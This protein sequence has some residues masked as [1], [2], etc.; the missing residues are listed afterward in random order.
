MSS[1]QSKNLA[2]ATA[3]AM[4]ATIG[5][6]IVSRRQSKEGESQKSVAGTASVNEM[7]ERHSGMNDMDV[8]KAVQGKAPSA[9]YSSLP[10]VGSNLKFVSNTS[11]QYLSTISAHPMY[12]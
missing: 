9:A 3:F 6:F 10:A 4:A 11:K 2:Y 5:G 1:P 7:G 8:R 12:H